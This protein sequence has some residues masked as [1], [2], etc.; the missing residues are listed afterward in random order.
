MLVV[1]V[2]VIAGWW[3]RLMFDSLESTGSHSLPSAYCRC[4]SDDQ[5]DFH[6]GEKWGACQA[7]YRT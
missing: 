5:R 2:V 1:V 4:T 7:E 6:L 3:P